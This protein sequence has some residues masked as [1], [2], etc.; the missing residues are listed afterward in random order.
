MCS[1]ML[2]ILLSAVSFMAVLFINCSGQKRPNSKSES[3]LKVSQ[4]SKQKKQES[5]KPKN[6]PS[7][8]K[9]TSSNDSKTSSNNNKEP[10]RAITVIWL[11]FLY[12]NSIL[13]YF[14]YNYVLT[15]IYF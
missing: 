1:D 2:M 15:V 11:S 13:W 8:E 10:V 14:F 5:K 3:K 7:K 9:P 6:L 4:K 12:S